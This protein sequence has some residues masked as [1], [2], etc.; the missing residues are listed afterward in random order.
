MIHQYPQKKYSK[1]QKILSFLLDTQKIK[2]IYFLFFMCITSIDILL[3]QPPPPPANLSGLELRNW[4]KTNWYDGKLVNSGNGLGYDEARR[5]MYGYIDK[6]TDNNI[7]CVYTGFKQAGNFVT[8]PNPINAEHTVPQSFFNESLPMVCDLHHL[9]PTHQTPNGTRSNNPFGEIIDTQ[10]TTWEGINTSNNFI[11]QSSIPMAAVIDNFSESRSS[12]YEPR[13]DQKG[14][15]ARAIFY[16]FTM[17]NIS[18]I[19]SKTISDL[20]NINTLY[21][22]HLQ[23]PPNQKERDRNNKIEEKQ[24]TRNPYI[25]YPESLASAWGF[26][27]I[28]FSTTSAVL[29]Q[30]ATQQ[31]Y[32]IPVRLSVLPTLGSASV[33]ISVDAS[34]TATLAD[35]TFSSPQTITFSAGSP[36]IQNIPITIK[37]NTATLPNRTI[38]LKLQNANNTSTG[39]S[40]T[41]TITILSGTNAIEDVFWNGFEIYPNPTK[42]I[43]NI[44]KT[45]QIWDKLTIM[46]ANGRVLEN[47]NNENIS[48]IDINHYAQG[49]YYFYFSYKGNAVLKKVVKL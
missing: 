14:N 8:F 28:S 3:A 37:S 32:Q 17:Y 25:D 16:F 18:S 29:V 10:T 33:E 24:G 11:S 22:W 23:D 5:Q 31:V 12:I 6:E 44:K 15:T 21:Q 27:N 43:I 40:N 35:Y 9:F 38:V 20:G 1:T 42:N 26:S 49:L 4:Y 30:S 19:N 39:T 47:I 7:T 45:N 2:I 46:D 34:S 41:H 48:Q 13:E 36:N